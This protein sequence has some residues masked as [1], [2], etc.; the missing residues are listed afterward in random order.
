MELLNP[1]RAIPMEKIIPTM[2]WSARGR[3]RGRDRA[4][5]PLA[6]IRGFYAGS[7]Q[8]FLV[9]LD[10]AYDQVY[11]TRDLSEKRNI[12]VGTSPFSKR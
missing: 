9:T 1:T 8:W 4:N 5:T 2:E 11:A 6:I 10:F 7:A 12:R 3:G